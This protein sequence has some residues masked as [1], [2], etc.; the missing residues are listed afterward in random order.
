M[1]LTML[2]AIVPLVLKAQA[3]RIESNPA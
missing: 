1:Q 3:E 2:T